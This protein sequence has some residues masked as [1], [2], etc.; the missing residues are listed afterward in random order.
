MFYCVAN[1]FQGNSKLALV[2][3]SSI[4]RRASGHQLQH[5][6]CSKQRCRTNQ[7]KHQEGKMGPGEMAQ[8]V[9][10]LPC[11]QETSLDPQI[12]CNSE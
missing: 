9:K 5:H 10:C 3:L 11:K 4:L 7:R 2:A 1:G 12:Q 8:W 6:V